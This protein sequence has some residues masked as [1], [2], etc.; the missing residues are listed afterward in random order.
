MAS[1]D[2]TRL[3]FGIMGGTA[4]LSRVI[5]HLSHD[6]SLTMMG[7]DQANLGVTRNASRE[8][9]FVYMERIGTRTLKK[10]ILSP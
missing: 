9:E 8:H 6:Y 4:V 3:S 7:M 2:R 10:E 1:N 5:E